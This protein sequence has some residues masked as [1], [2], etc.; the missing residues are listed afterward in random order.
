MFSFGC[1]L[2][3]LKSDKIIKNLRGV[4]I[5]SCFEESKDILLNLTDAPTHKCRVYPLHLTCKGN[6]QGLTAPTVSISAVS[7]CRSTR[8]DPAEG[9]MVH[10]LCDGSHPVDPPQ[11]RPAEPDRGAG[12]DRPR[13]TSCGSAQPLPW[14]TMLSIDPSNM[15]DIPGRLGAG[16]RSRAHSVL[17]PGKW[18]FGGM[19]VSLMKSTTA[20][21]GIEPG[22]PE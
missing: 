18:V 9:A 12:R 13:R 10:S 21:P 20:P 3:Q 14:A 8:I 22:F 15:I 6:L 7:P 16:F 1:F 17:T 11:D 2:D 5:P 19:Y 4:E